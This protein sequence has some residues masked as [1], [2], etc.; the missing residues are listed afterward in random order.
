MKQALTVLW[1]PLQVRHMR[2]E[3]SSV[4]QASTAC[5]TPLLV[6]APEHSWQAQN[7]LSSSGHVLHLCISSSPYTAGLTL[8]ASAMRTY[9]LLRIGRRKTVFGAVKVTNNLPWWDLADNSSSSRH[10]CNVF[11]LRWLPQLLVFANT[12]RFRMI[13]Q[14]P[15]F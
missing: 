3:K 5:F 4:P 7:V 9:F 8:S 13:R 2:A 12:L 10:N 6:I 11:F 14:T 1:I 15:T